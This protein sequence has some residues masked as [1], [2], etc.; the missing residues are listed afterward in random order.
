MVPWGIGSPEGPLVTSST[1]GLGVSSSSSSPFSKAAS[2]PIPL[3]DFTRRISALSSPLK[4]TK[5]AINTRGHAQALKSDANV[6]NHSVRK[7][8]KSIGTVIVKHC[9][10]K[11]KKPIF[12]ALAFASVMR[13][14]A[15]PFANCKLMC[16]VYRKFGRTEV[17]FKPPLCVRGNVLRHRNRHRAPLETI[18][19][20]TS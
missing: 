2:T 11:A 16:A 20:T 6:L 9:Q 10:G 14:G 5:K 18:A 3:N 1:T 13:Q 12:T 17:L 4:N 8:A 19:A 7:V 15:G